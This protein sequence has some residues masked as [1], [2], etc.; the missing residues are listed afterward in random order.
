[1]ISEAA[2]SEI[3]TGNARAAQAQ[4]P[5]GLA[6]GRLS[7]AQLALLMRM[8]GEYTAGLPADVADR[9]MRVVRAGGIG[10]VHFAWAGGGSPGAPHYYRVQGPGFLVEYDNTQNGANHVHTVWRELDGDFG[11]DLLAEHHRQAHRR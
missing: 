2:P 1:V 9:R 6:A 5:A 11:R 8:L 3:L 4:N 7:G 10:Q